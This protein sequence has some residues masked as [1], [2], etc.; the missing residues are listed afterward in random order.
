MRRG[1]RRRSP[2][3]NEDRRAR[4]YDDDYHLRDENR[5]GDDNRRKSRRPSETQDRHRPLIRWCL[6]HADLLTS[7]EKNDLLLTCYGYAFADPSPAQLRIF[8]TIADRVEL[9]LQVRE[10][11]RNRDWKGRRARR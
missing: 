5:D 7:W 11:R 6:K 1:Q 8:D 9:G 10:D 3:T 4:G 2:P